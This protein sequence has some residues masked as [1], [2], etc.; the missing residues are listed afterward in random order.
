MTGS[1]HVFLA[2]R[3]TG[4]LFNLFMTADG[5][6][7]SLSMSPA[8]RWLSLVTQDGLLLYDL[9]AD[10]GHIYVDGPLD[11]APQWSPSGEWLYAGS[12]GRHYLVAPDLENREVTAEP[13][14]CRY[15]LWLGAD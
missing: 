4:Q 12:D 1:T 13:L 5:D 6:P 11:F 7:Q 10:R 15:A 8:G 2:R 3:D 9:V 14:A